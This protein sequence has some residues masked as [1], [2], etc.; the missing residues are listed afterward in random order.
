MDNGDG[1]VGARSTKANAISAPSA[2]RCHIELDNTGVVVMVLVANVVTD[3]H[4]CVVGYVDV[5]IKMT[6]LIGRPG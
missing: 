1:V 2:S 3:L 5:T 4:L 6:F